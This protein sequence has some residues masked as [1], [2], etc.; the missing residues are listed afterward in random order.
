MMK[1]FWLIE[2]FCTTCTP[3]LGLVRCIVPELYYD[4][5]SHDYG[6]KLMQHNINSLSGVL[7]VRWRLGYAATAAV[8]ALYD[9]AGVCS[10]T[11]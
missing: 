11:R 7:T 2:F 10:G 4:G 6:T 1:L 9:G 5:A 8:R 3:H